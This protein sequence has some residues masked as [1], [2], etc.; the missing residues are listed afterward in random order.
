MVKK[1]KKNIY[2][3]IAI[4]IIL[5][6]SIVGWKF[7]DG[8]QWKNPRWEGKSSE[9]NWKAVLSKDKNSNSDK[10]FGML[11]WT[12]NK[13][14]EKKIYITLSQFYINDKYV[15]GDRAERVSKKEQIV[16]DKDNRGFVDWEQLENIKD[17]KLVVYLHWKQDNQLHKTKIQ[18]KKVTDH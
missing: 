13:K 8:N 15:A 7:Y 9:G 16:T 5:L 10:F 3:I 14:D 1:R 6:S 2:L 17:N 18:L 12:G 11:Y 4:V